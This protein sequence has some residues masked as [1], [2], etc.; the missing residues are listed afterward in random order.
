MAAWVAEVDDAAVR[1]T[2][3]VDIILHRAD[4]ERAKEAMAKA[5]FVHQLAAGIDMFMDGASTKMRDAVHVV[6]AA[7]KVRDEKSLPGS[8]CKRVETSP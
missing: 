7:E 8:G 3:D 2:Q 5:G 6:F 1:N 4:L